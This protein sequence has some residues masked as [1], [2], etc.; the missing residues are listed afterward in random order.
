MML[1]EDGK[2]D[3]RTSLVLEM[4]RTLGASAVGITTRETIDPNE[5][6]MD[7]DFVLKGA[8]AAVTFAVPFEIGRAHV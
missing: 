8:R 6:T 3:E 7:Y 4:A 1:M 5:P 2:N